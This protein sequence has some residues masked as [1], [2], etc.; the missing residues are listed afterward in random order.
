LPKINNLINPPRFTGCRGRVY[1]DSELQSNIVC[2]TRP[3]KNW[4]FNI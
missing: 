3:Y 4:D 2:E 1:I